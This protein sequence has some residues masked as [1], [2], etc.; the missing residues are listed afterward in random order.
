MDVCNFMNDFHANAKLP[1]GLNSSFIAFISKFSNPSRIKDYRP[2]SL[3][4]SLF[5]ILSKVLVGWLKAINGSL[6]SSSQS[7]FIQNRCILDAVVIINEVI[8]STKNNRSGYFLLKV[9][10]EKAYD[11]VN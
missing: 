11:S 8:D 9:D 2:I 6:I 5:K 3:V 10:F 7:A 4:G 1:N